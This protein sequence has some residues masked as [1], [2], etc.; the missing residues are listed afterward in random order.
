MAAKISRFIDFLLAPSG[1]KDTKNVPEKQSH[2][3]KKRQRRCYV[4]TGVEPLQDVRRFIQDRRPGERHHNEREDIPERKSED[5]AHHDKAECRKSADT[6]YRSEPREI[7][8]RKQDREGEAEE[9]PKRDDTGLE[10][11]GGIAACIG[12]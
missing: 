9:K 4:L 6:Q 11:H 7:R 10:D 8:S 12:G 1:A 5:R 2:A 3:R